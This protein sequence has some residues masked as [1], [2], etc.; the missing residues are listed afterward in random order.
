MDSREFNIEVVKEMIES[1]RNKICKL[2]YANEYE[3]APEAEQIIY[4]CIER[5]EE[6]IGE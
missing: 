6:L 4:D 1:A 2:E 3:I 5:L